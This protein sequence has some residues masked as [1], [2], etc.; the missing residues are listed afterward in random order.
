MELPCLYYTND[1]LQRL[2]A[3]REKAINLK[4][5]L[6]RKAAEKLAWTRRNPERVSEIAAGV[7]ARAK[8]SG[9]HR[10]AICNKNL[11]S[12]TALNTHLKT[13][14]HKERLRLAR[15]GKAKPVSAKARRASLLCQK[16][17]IYI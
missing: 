11:A 17:Y 3:Q 8:A 9:K 4:A 13:K 16:I 1:E 7:R 12:I 15:G 14:A 5:Y 6:A 10:C 2:H